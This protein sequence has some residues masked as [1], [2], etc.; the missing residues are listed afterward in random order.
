[1]QKDREARATQSRPHRADLTHQPVG[2]RNRVLATGG[3]A[4]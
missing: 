3:F 2:P 1:V 4:T